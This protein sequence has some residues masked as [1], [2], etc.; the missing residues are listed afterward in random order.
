M[1]NNFDHHL[2][3]ITKQLYDKIISN[4]KYKHLEGK[5]LFDWIKNTAS[6]VYNKVK[7]IATGIKNV[8]TGNKYS[9]L[10]NTQR[11][12][13]EYGKYRVTKIVVF[14][15]PILK[16]IDGTLKL[17]SLGKWEQL[18]GKYG[19]DAF[20][21]LSCLMTL[22]TGKQLYIEKNANIE[23]TDNYSTNPETETL[24][25]STEGK[26]IFFGKMF[27]LGRKNVGDQNWFIY[28]GFANNCQDFILALLGS[29]NLVTN[30]VYDFIKQ[31]M[32]ELINELPSYVINIS[33]KVTDLGSIF[34]KLIGGKKKIILQKS[35]DP[36]K[37]FMVKIGDKTIHFGDK[38]GSTYID[39]KNDKLKDAYIARHKVN[40][41]WNDINS[42]GFWSRWLLWEKPIL[43]EAINDIE[44]R[45][46]IDIVNENNYIGGS[47]WR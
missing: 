3:F 34:Q 45:F 4:S 38:S 10:N 2:N 5:G 27:E 40:E 20:F 14:R 13:N 29:Y 39:H 21:H 19:Y 26:I 30:S 15:T 7:D 12:L 35:N 18:K 11:K 33:K 23:I 24:N 32:G 9:Y 37:R 42:A 44:K 25:V 28:D 16:V 43:T 22:E 6:K 47:H 8:V 1:N 31:D 46:D 36:D 17:I 41:N